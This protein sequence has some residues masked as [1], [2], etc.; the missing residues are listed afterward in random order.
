MDVRGAALDRVDQ[1][2]VDELDDRRVV[3]ARGVDAGSLA[4]LF[5]VAAFEVELVEAFGVVETVDGRAR[6]IERLLDRAARAAL[7]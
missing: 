5:E 4:S 2:L 6:R 7:R 3:V 1:H